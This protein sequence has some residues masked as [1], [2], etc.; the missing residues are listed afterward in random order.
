MSN[1]GTELGINYLN[2]EPNS[3]SHAVGWDRNQVRTEVYEFKTNA[4]YT[5]SYMWWWGPRTQRFD[6]SP[7]MPIRYI[8]STGKEDYVTA[9]GNVTGSHLLNK[10]QDN[11]LD[12][13]S[14]PLAAN[15]TYYITFFPGITREEGWGLY[16]I[17][18]PGNENWFT[19]HAT[20]N[21]H[22]SCT[23]PTS[24]TLDNSILVPE[25]TTTLRWDGAS[26]GNGLT[27]S[28]YDIYRSTSPRGTYT[29][30]GSTL[31]GSTTSYQV[32]APTRRGQSYY[33]K[34]V[35][36][37]NITDYDSGLSRAS[38]GLKANTL[39]GAPTIDVSPS[40]CIIPSTG[41]T[42]TFTV[43]PGADSDGQSLTLYY[44]TNA[45]QTKSSFSSPLSLTLTQSA[46]YYFYT[47]DGL[48][49]S[50]YTSKTISTNEAPSIDSINCTL[51]TYDA[52]GG[53][54]EDGYQL[55]YASTITPTITTNK[56]GKITFGI[57]YYPSNY[58][59]AWSAPSGHGQKNIVENRDIA[60]G[61]TPFSLINLHG[62]VSIPTTQNIH[63][64]FYAKLTDSAGEDTGWVYFPADDYYYSIARPSEI[65]YKYNQFGNSNITG[66]ND[67][68]IYKRVRL[69][70]QKDESIS[71]MTTTATV[72]GVL[73]NAST[74]VSSDQAGF[75][76]IDIEFSNE[77]PGGK[78]I[79]IEVKQKDSSGIIAKNLTCQVAETKTPALGTLSYG[80]QRIWPFTQSGD[81]EIGTVWPFGLHEQI[82][83]TT[84]Q[85][86]NCSTDAQSAIKFVFSS[87]NIGNGANRVIK[88]LTWGRSGD[89]MKTEMGREDVYDWNHALGI[90]T[91]SG[92]H[93]YYCRLEI[94]NLFGRTTT[95]PWVA[96]VLD[97]SELVQ[98]PTITSIDW[99]LDGSTNWAS[100]GDNA[101]QEGIYLRF[102]CSFGLFTTDNVTVTMLLKNSSGERSISCHEQ[103]SPQKITPIEYTD[104]EL[105]RATGRTAASNTK[106]YIYH[107]T[108][109][110]TD[111]TARQWRLCFDNTGGT[112]YSEYIS[113]PVIRQCAPDLTL[114]QCTTDEDYVISY[115]YS[116]TDKGFDT[117]NEDNSLTNYLADGTTSIS[118]AI[119]N[120]TGTS[121]SGTVEATSTGWDSKAI[122]VKMV[123]VVDGLYTNTKTYYS[124][125]II[126]YQLSPT[127]AYRKN[128]LGINTENP[129]SG[130]IVDIR[131]STGRNTILIQGFTSDY[132]PAKFEIDVSTGQ[133]KFY[134]HDTSQDTDVLKN[135]IDL[136]NGFLT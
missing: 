84:L 65:L 116:M 4:E 100:L 89:T 112:S 117:S 62:I 63:W 31:N 94:T 67:G 66:T 1:Y 134:L 82:N 131:Q 15:T 73:M 105:D 118:A 109:E 135:T 127:V 35:T 128:Q 22:T 36:K 47:Y 6:E 113:T 45:G 76:Y 120:T 60:A 48:E 97:F 86:Y 104:R 53:D 79:N 46:T 106:S 17:G 64:R 19:I 56:A 25:G 101:I 12:F 2:G 88:N 91:Y 111:T 54:G 52:L 24:V 102:N 114:T 80:A 34:I 132:V 71:S 28:S 129:T 18:D 87:S 49:F 95:T 125:I 7:E 21:M 30:I 26:A 103:G 38:A 74:T 57:E 50:T 136:M 70:V 83:A 23:P 92:S 29:K 40:S 72:D 85:D 90:S 20:E 44:S 122:C 8:I 9:A 119:L 37:A 77:I 16:Y 124:N 123:S 5:T 98:S 96:N 13:S 110:I 11:D 27:I 39:P 121:V 51:G 3:G 69:K 59:T 42:V 14:S 108:T 107:V 58:T 133:I 61:S 126:V 10:G 55:G 115:T 130:A 93:T 78:E 32:S 43:T 41:G 68:E 81:F 99:S 75:S 33:Y